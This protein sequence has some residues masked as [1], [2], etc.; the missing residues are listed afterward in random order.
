MSTNMINPIGMNNYPP[1]PIMPAQP[2]TIRIDIAP[3][4]MGYPQIQAQ[5]QQNSVIYNIPQT[6]VFEPKKAE[7][8][9]VTEKQI[10]NKKVETKAVETKQ[11]E[12]KSVENTMAQVLA[13]QAGV[14]PPAATQ[15]KVAEAAPKQEK[16]EPKK[17]V[18]QNK[19]EI[20][21]PEKMKA[22]IDLNGLISILT[23]PD[24]EE[25]ADA[26]EAVSEVA[27]YAPD[28]AGELLD[29]KVVNTLQDIMSKDTSKLQGKD[30]ELADRNKEFAMFTTATLQK[31]YADE[32]KKA[33]NVDVPP[34]DLIGINGV[35]NNLATNPNP[36][37]R[38]AAVA[39][40]GFVTNPTNKNVM[41]PLMAQAAQDVDAKVRAQAEK[42]LG[43]VMS[44]N[45]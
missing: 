37:I 34:Q 45:A 10:E 16:T 12:K 20:V 32:I 2:V 41:A 18:K 38:E 1:M 22:G 42:Q 27:L 17:E 30:K 43:K 23:S 29:T 13:A 11:E 31:L 40:L 15:A 7:E 14:Q 44:F 19:P 39:S 33:G 28:R 5:P 9:K 36:S 4:Q 21:A 3:Q 35:V 8:E 26:M 25:Q 6:S 24:Y